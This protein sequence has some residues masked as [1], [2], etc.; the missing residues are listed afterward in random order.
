LKS[1]SLL[2]NSSDSKHSGRNGIIGV[3]GLKAWNAIVMD[4]KATANF[5][6]CNIRK[7]GTMCITKN[8]RR[9]ASESSRAAATHS[10]TSK[11]NVTFCE[12]GGEQN[13]EGKG[14]ESG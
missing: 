6:R 14:D 1:A 13:N 9:Q 5:Q 4:G 8:Q 10:T 7:L 11:K 12:V 3:H 2:L